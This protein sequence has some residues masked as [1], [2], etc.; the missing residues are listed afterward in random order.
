[1]SRQQLIAVTLTVAMLLSGIAAVGVASTGAWTDQHEQTT[2]DDELQ[3][4]VENAT[5]FVV[6]D[7]SNVPVSDAGDMAGDTTDDNE[8]DTGVGTDDNETDDGVG[9]DDNESDDTGVGTDDAGDHQTSADS[10]D[11]FDNVHMQVTVEAPNVVDLQ[12]TGMDASGAADATGDDAGTDESDANDT[13]SEAGD[14]GSMDGAPSGD[15]TIEQATV[16][17]VIDDDEY[18]GADG[19]TSL[20]DSELDAASIFI[21][22]GDETD[23]S[24]MGDDG[25]GTDDNETD[26]GVGTDDNETDDGVGTDDDETEDATDTG[27][28]DGGEVSI[29][30]ATIF[31]YTQGSLS[32]LTGEMGT[33]TTDDGVGMDDNETDDGVGMDDNETDGGVGMDDSEDDSTTSEVDTSW[34]VERATIYV[35]AHEDM[36]GSED[37]GMGD[38]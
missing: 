11:R 12:E 31:V 2:D 38:E 14:T 29:D 15:L 20:T 7:E 27:M 4:T 13:E 17:V 28:D 34:T 5:V 22:V 3:V 32:D 19:D 33:D 1:M 8:T 25:V 16:F 36:M 21:I 23:D 9:T 37:A 10:V 26:N 18:T 35:Y 24:T 30:T 6:P